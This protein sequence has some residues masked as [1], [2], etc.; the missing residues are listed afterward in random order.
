MNVNRK[1]RIKER[2]IEEDKRNKENETSKT[3]KE[4]N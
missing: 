4:R 2:K 1:N 3:K